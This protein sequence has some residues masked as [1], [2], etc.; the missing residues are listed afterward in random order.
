MSHIYPNTSNLSDSIVDNTS[1]ASNLLQTSVE[2]IIFLSSL[3]ILFQYGFIW[4]LFMSD[5]FITD[6]M[7]PHDLYG[8]SDL[9]F[10]DFSIPRVVIFSDP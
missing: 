10:K 8:T 7:A 6:H 1:L 2:K 3:L 5:H 9:I 4:F